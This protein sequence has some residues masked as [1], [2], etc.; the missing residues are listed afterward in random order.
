MNIEKDQA[1]SMQFFTTTI[2]EKDLKI[3]ELQSD[4]R[5]CNESIKSKSLNISKLNETIEERNE[6]EDIEDQT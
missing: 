2:T 5:K 1:E 3:D 4:L 6:H